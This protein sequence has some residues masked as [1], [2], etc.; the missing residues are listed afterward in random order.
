MKYAT[1]LGTKIPIG[2]NVQDFAF[3]LSKFHVTGELPL[4]KPTKE[5]N[6]L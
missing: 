5:I 1:S 3:Y 2:Q 6:L 4:A